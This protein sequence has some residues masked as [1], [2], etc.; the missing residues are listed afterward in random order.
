MSYSPEPLRDGSPSEKSEQTFAINLFLLFLAVYLLTTSW[1]EFSIADVSR[2]RIEVTRSL[3]EKFD[4]SVP[5]GIGMEGA[6]GREYSW[7]GIGPVLLATPFFVSGKLLGFAPENALPII[8]QLLG[9]ATAVLI[10]LFSYSLGYSRRASLTVAVFYG[11]GTAAWFLS[12]DPGDHAMEI[13]FIVLSVYFMT[14]YGTRRKISHL[15]VSAVSVGVAFITRP[16][17]ILILPPLLILLIAGHSKQLDTLSTGK[18]TVRD[19]ILF[20]SVFSPFLCIS[21]WYNYYRFGSIFETGHSLMA[22][23]MGID[24][25]T[26]TPLLVGLKG[27]L[28]SPGKGF[29]YYSPVTTLFFFSI[30]PFIKRHRVLAICFLSIIISYL[31]FLSENIYW[32]GDCTWGPRYIYVA[33]PF[34]MIPV[35]ALIDSPNWKLNKTLKT[36]VYFLFGVSFAIQVA[37]VAVHGKRYF[38]YLQGEEKIKF[39]VSKGEGVQS[40]VEPPPQIYFDWHKSP[41]AEQFRF[42]YEIAEAVK[43]YRASNLST[44][45]MP[46][47][48]MRKKMIMTIFDFWWLHDYFQRGSY[49]GFLAAF[50]LISVAIWAGTIIW[51]TAS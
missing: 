46:F 41:I 21:F 35:A 37:A 28:I 16:T 33:L 9:A 43:G 36:V 40:I 1:I 48:R 24:F 31:L 11:L 15:L 20:F 4:L 6:D 25:F 45:T 10:C 13:F 14:L 30:K 22:A 44:N 29:F 47:E 5:K 39:T 34:L 51:K 42:M 18:V 27:F 8:N 12:K 26:G 3:M 38:F 32:H 2:N 49:S 19:V 17:S 23:R 7:F 50:I